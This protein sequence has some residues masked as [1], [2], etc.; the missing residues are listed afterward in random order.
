M[1]GDDWD[2]GGKKGE[3]G[4]CAGIRGKKGN[5]SARNDNFAEEP[6][7]ARADASRGLI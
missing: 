7:V 3:K 1:E 2:P 6:R 5:K 4:D